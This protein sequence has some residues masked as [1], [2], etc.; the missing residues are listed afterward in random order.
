MSPLKTVPSVELLPTV[1]SFVLA[2]LSLLV[3]LMLIVLFALALAAP[4]A[5][6]LVLPYVPQ[7]APCILLSWQERT[8]PLHLSAFAWLLE[9]HSGFCIV[10]HRLVPIELA[11]P[12]V[13]YALVPFV[14]SVP[15]IKLFGLLALPLLL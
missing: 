7:S 3:P 15:A 4:F 12:I 8:S 13:M 10:P 2:L 9:W 6:P 1:A 14:I 11:S 5:E